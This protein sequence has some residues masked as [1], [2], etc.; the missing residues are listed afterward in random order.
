MDDDLR[1]LL[2][3]LQHNG[4]SDP[5]E[6]FITERG[7]KAHAYADEALPI[8]CEQTKWPRVQAGAAL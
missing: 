8:E 4:I 1:D 2:Y 5:R 7:P 6:L 3:S